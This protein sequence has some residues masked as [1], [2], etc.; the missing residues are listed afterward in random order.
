MG[1]MTGC[2]GWLEGVYISGT[3]LLN[4]VWVCE[5]HTGICETSYMYIF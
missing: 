2:I 4:R 3:G 1:F 5:Q